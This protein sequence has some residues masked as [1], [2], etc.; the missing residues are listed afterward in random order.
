MEHASLVAFLGGKISP[1]QF[2]REIAEEVSA[3]N[4]SRRSQGGGRIIITDGPQTV[5]T[6][7]HAKRLLDA[8]VGGQLTIESANY[9]AS[10]IIFGDF[11]FADEAVNAAV[12]L[13]EM[14]DLDKPTLEDLQTAAARLI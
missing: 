10:C 14:A 7:E 1:E 3:C 8:V 9:T 4:Q 6:R 2:G 11:E 5:V 12:W 13:I